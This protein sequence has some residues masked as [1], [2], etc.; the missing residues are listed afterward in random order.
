VGER[1]DLDFSRPPGQRRVAL[2]PYTRVNL[3]AE[4]DLDRFVLS[5]RIE[6]LL[7]DQTQEIA[8]FRPR[9]RTVLVGGR[10]GLGL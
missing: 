6:N 8:G 10:V 9:G 1:V 2:D 5:G 3:A 7:D 4:Y